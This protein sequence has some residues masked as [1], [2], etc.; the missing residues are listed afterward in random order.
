VALAL[1][2]PNLLAF[3]HSLPGAVL[4]AALAL[5]ALCLAWLARPAAAPGQG[6]A[7]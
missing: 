2:L 1:A 7:S 3:G 6:A 5:G 4:L